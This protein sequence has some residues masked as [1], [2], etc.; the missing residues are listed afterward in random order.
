MNP[1]TV[2]PFHDVRP[3][4]LDETKARQ[5]VIDW[6]RQ[7]A[8]GVHSLRDEDVSRHHNS[9][10]VTRF[11]SHAEPCGFE[12]SLLATGSPAE[13]RFVG[14][15]S[16]HRRIVRLEIPDAADRNEARVLACA[17]LLRD[18]I[19]KHRLF[20]PQPLRHAA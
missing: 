16:W 9:E 14:S 6:L 4:P 1:T 7:I 20:R 18:E 8:G 5:E 17:A 11:L 2:F 3:R 12:L 13:P 15:W 10:V 19:L